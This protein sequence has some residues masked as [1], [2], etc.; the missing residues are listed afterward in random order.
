MDD[1][2]ETRIEWIKQEIYKKTLVNEFYSNQANDCNEA[3]A[4][5]C[6]YIQRLNKE[7]TALQKPKYTAKDFPCLGYLFGHGI[8]FIDNNNEYYISA[9]LKMI[10]NPIK[11]SNE[12][13]DNIINIMECKLSDIKAG[14][15]F[16]CI[17]YKNDIGKY[18]YCTLVT[19]TIIRYDYGDNGYIK[20]HYIDNDPTTSNTYVKFILKDK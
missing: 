20:N 1:K 14:D 3:I 6:D 18:R 4:D 2:V 5:N 9:K 11:H 15:Y 8:A 10:S 13:I 12:Y 7:L 17:D 16:A 19:E